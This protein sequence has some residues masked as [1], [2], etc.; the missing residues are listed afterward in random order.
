MKLRVC[1]LVLITAFP[2]GW[3]EGP[4]GN[5]NHLSL[6]G[7]SWGGGRGG[8]PAGPGGE[9]EMRTN[10]WEPLLERGDG[11]WP[12]LPQGG[13]SSLP[14][15]LPGQNLAS[16]TH[17]AR[18]PFSGPA[19]ASVRKSGT[20]GAGLGGSS[21][22]VCDAFP[23]NPALRAALLF[24]WL[25]TRRFWP[26]QRGSGHHLTVPGGLEGTSWGRTGG[27][28]L[29]SRS[30]VAEPRLPAAVLVCCLRRR[31]CRLSRPRLLLLLTRAAGPTSSLS[32]PQS[33]AS[34]HSSCR[35]GPGYHP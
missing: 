20:W 15:E 10:G 19:A 30:A 5:N 13:A 24:P 28:H 32:I 2:E 21:P 11:V 17:T 18:Q 26:L 34:S 14:P 12:L 31:R 9:G 23:H 6:E 27:A 7:R 16:E 22:G 35:L 25:V 8:G 29:C 4:A 1:L 33:L 3:R